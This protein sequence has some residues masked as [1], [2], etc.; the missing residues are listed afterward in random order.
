M[1]NEE[2][3]TRVEARAIASYELARAEDIIKQTV[4]SMA[5]MT[6]R[7]NEFKSTF[8]GSETTHESKIREII[9]YAG[10]QADLHSA[11]YHTY[12]DMS[13]LLSDFIFSDYGFTD[14]DEET[15]D[16]IRTNLQ[17]ALDLCGKLSRE[18]E[19]VAQSLGIDLADKPQT[20]ITS[21]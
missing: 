4:K 10:F 18:P 6:K 12:K 16:R 13:Q 9:S 1:R 17:A 3:R 20:M 11:A 19:N 14:E 21:Y 5:F 15:Q 2:I 8:Y 7:H